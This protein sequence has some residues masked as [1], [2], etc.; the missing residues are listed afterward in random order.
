M[1]LKTRIITYLKNIDADIDRDTLIK[2]A[3]K[4]GYSKEKV[5]DA[6]REIEQTVSNI[7][8]WQDPKTKVNYLR[9]YPPNDL[10]NKVRECLDCGDDW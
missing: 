3:E 10:T 5:Y 2:V 8:Q 7:G 9:Y 4:E 1:K 6:L